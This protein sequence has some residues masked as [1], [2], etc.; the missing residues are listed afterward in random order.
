MSVKI[1]LKESAVNR[2]AKSLAP[3]TFPP[4]DGFYQ[5]DSLFDRM[6]W[7]Y[8][9]YRERVFRDDTNRI[10]GAFWPNSRPAHGTTVLELGCGP[11]FYSR[12]LAARFPE[13]SIT[14]VDRSQSQ[15][16]CARLRAQKQGLH[17]CSF[18]HVNAQQIRSEDGC[19]DV[20]V[21]SRLF[22]VLPQPET[23]IGE[24][25]RVLRPGGRC[26]V[27]EPRYAL[28]A[29]IPLI[30]MWLLAA[31]ILSENRYREPRKATV[32]TK[33]AFQKLFSSQPWKKVEIWQDGRYQY[34]ICEKS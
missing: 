23:V 16:Q 32:F 4:Q 1:E 31:V 34:A 21:A 15:L 11:G 14:G 3:T 7:L 8:A 29:S 19:F 6:P 25:F 18:E 22:T 27:A 12:R 5:S 24:M 28:W 13:I 20:L 33:S 10:V 9:F 30:A 17:N 2:I 26:F